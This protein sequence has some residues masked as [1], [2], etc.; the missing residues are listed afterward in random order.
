MWSCGG[1]V[2]FMYDYYTFSLISLSFLSSPL[3]LFFY[4]PI[5][6]IPTCFWLGCLDFLP[7][8]G[9]RHSHNSLMPLPQEIT[10]LMMI[11][12]PYPERVSIVDINM[13]FALVMYLIFFL[14][15]EAI[16]SKD[17]AC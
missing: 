3:V 4:I 8:I 2:Y 5:L 16:C 15:S 11:L 9:T 10:L 12:S 7:L 1:I 13:C 6:Y 17:V 14:F